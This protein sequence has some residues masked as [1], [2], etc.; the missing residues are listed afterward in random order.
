MSWVSAA[1]WRILLSTSCILAGCEPSTRRIQFRE[2]IQLHD[3]QKLIAERVLTI[4]VLGEIGGPGGWEPLSES[5]EIIGPQHSD[6]PPKW[7]SP[8]G[9][10]P[11]LLDR[12]P[13]TSQWAMIASFIMCDPWVKYGRPKV[14]YIEFR[15]RDGQW[16]RVEFS[17]VWLGRKTNVFSRIRS[18]G[19]PPMLSIEDKQKRADSRTAKW[20]VQ[21]EDH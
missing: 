12:A 2:E 5:L 3:E 1:S 14:P 6:H 15:V 20:Y 8:D 4:K 9:L 7:T 19:E 16:Q 10:V 21:I 18:S 13:D 11:L 17:P